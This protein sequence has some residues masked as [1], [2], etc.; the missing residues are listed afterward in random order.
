MPA[1]TR[2]AF[3]RLE[4]QRPLPFK[5]RGSDLVRG[6]ADDLRRGISGDVIA[7]RFHNSVAR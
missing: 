7:A 6:V 4:S 1:C 2:T 5:F 3:T